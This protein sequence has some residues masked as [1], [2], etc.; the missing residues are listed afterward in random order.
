M[1]NI[2]ALN[3]PALCA[4]TPVG[5]LQVRFWG[6]QVSVAV[7]DRLAPEE[8]PGRIVHDLD[9]RGL[10]G[11]L[12]GK[13]FFAQRQVRRLYEQLDEQRKEGTAREKA[14]I[15]SDTRRELVR[16]FRRH[17]DD[18]RAPFHRLPRRR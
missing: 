6:G 1:P 18:M 12:Y 15:S 17:G 10:L 9:D 11:A 4:D 2:D 7:R 5:A 13:A 3:D 14:A 16:L 8:R